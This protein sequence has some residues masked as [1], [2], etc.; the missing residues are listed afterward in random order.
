[1]HDNNLALFKTHALPLINPGDAVL[2]IGPEQA[3]GAIGRTLVSQRHGTYYFADIKNVAS[4]MSGYVEMKGEYEIDSPSD[5]FDVV[6]SLSVGEHVRKLWCWAQELVRVT[7]PGGFVVFVTPFSW[8]YHE[9]PYDCWRILP[10]GYKALFEDAGLEHVFSWHG[11]VL[12]L[13]PLWQREH[14]PHTVTD[15]I[16][17]GRKCRE[18]K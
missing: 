5:R 7:R 17:I 14:G 15:T 18:T 8:P 1:M 13:E 2:E 3:G 11:N 16:A 6:F 10:E 9:S 12:P 4:T